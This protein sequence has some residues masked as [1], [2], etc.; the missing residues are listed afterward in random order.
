M[1]LLQSMST[2]GKLLLGASILGIAVL[3]F[4]LVSLATKPTYQTLSAGLDPAQTGKLTA[5]LDSQGITYRLA[6]GGT[7]I[8]V[9]D[10]DVPKARIA[11]AS[12]GLGAGGAAA[13]GGWDK[14]DKQKLGASDFQQKVAYQ[15]ALEAQIAQTIGQ[16]SGAQGATVQLTMPEDQLFADEQKPAT[17]A[18][19]LGGGASTLEAGAVRGIANLV[20]SSVPNLK[21]ANVTI[22][23]ASGQMLWPT[24]EAGGAGGGAV[25]KTAAEGRYDAQLSNEL[26][27]I[28]AR[29]V[30]PDKA[31]VR[32]KSDLNVDNTQRDEL[33]YAK[34]GTPIKTTEDTERLRGTGSA[35]GGGAGARSNIPTYAASGAG[36]GGNSNYQRKQSSTD[37]GVGKVVTHTKVAPG[38]VQRLDVAVLVDPSVPPKTAKALQQAISSAA[39]INT[40]RGDTITLSS[41]P[42]AKQTATTAKPRALPVDVLPYAKWGGIGL[43]SLLFL[44]FVSRHLRKRESADLLGEPVWL[45]QIESPRP[46][47]ELGAGE[48][49]TQPLLTTNPNRRRQQVEQAVQREPE[50]VVQALRGWLAEDEDR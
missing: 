18:V 31:Q 46:V 21:A 40:Q 50:R 43:A 29:T 12:Q 37:F 3:A 11:L 6:N 32:V 25:S 42:F 1:S 26:N 39:G 5:A 38:A 34:Q 23:D 17:A 48:S 24:G 7:A 4:L 20:A 13:Q 27:A 14:F 8:D 33:Q 45:H 47:G 41:V 22:T 35:A 16:V 49:A 15:R 10:G 28:V 2:R 9:A 36:A 44:F 19:L 30:G